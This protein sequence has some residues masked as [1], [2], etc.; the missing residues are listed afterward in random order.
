MIVVSCFEKTIVNLRNK[1]F[2]EKH[3]VILHQQLSEARY[4]FKRLL[5]ELFTNLLPV[6]QSFFSKIYFL[7]YGDV[8]HC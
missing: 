1:Y 2:R 4:I 7:L 8:L 5:E 6:I 3:Y